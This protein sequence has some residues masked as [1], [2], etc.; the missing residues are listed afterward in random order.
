MGEGLRLPSVRGFL[1]GYRAGGLYVD[2]DKAGSRGPG[3]NRLCR[4]GGVSGGDV[5]VPL[6]TCSTLV[7]DVKPSACV[8]VPSSKEAAKASDCRCLDKE[9][10]QA[11]NAADCRSAICHCHIAYRNNR[12]RDQAGCRRVKSKFA[13]RCERTFAGLARR[14]SRYYC[15]RPLVLVGEANVA[16]SCVI[17]V[18]RRCSDDKI[19]SVLCLPWS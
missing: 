1:F 6:S 16:D 12:S 11:Q 19:P 4:V 17:V 8:L 5:I 3:W 10:I 18:N 14:A 2:V 15:A 9:V 7:R 13:C